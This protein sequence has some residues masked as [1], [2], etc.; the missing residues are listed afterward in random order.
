MDIAARKGEPL[1]LVHPTCH[2]VVRE[3][4]AGQ[5]LGS[6]GQVRVTG[7]TYGATRREIHESK[8]RL[9]PEA[10]LKNAC[11]PFMP[12]SDN[13][14]LRV[15]DTSPYTALGFAVNRGALRRAALTARAMA[16]VTPAV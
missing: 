14:G 1:C 10:P 9:L 7:K 3:V 8:V 12:V 16:S 13:I 2:E 4:L 15:Y 5:R 11:V 6:S